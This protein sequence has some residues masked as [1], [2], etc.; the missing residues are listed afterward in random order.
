MQEHWPEQA[1]ETAAER[2]AET[3]AENAAVTEQAAQQPPASSVSNDSGPARRRWLRIAL[4]GTGI[5]VAGAIAALLSIDL[6]ITLSTRSAITDAVEQVQPV[7]VALL[8]GTSRGQR[9][10]PNEF[11]QAR[12]EAAAQ[13]YH[14]CRVRGILV[15][16]D[17]ATRYYNEPITMQKDLIALGVA[18]DHITL[19]YAGFR[20]LDSIIRAKKV[21]GLD[22]VLI[23]SQ[24]FH[25]ARAIFLARQ[26]GIDARG[27]AAANPTHSGYL[28][29]RAREVLAR[30][31][32]VLDIVTGQGARFLGAPETLRLRSR[33]ATNSGPG[34]PS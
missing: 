29:I 7:E 31:A 22:Q 12:I 25:A 15:S 20:T 33:P 5:M 30:A 14:S 32:A 9:S 3:A 10:N 27:F 26:F 21:F 11:Y 34:H 18:A 6:T 17:N 28:K 19:D 23:V 24:D 4:L 1:T 13:L 8:L 16:G 2:A